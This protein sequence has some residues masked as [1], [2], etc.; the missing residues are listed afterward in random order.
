MALGPR[1]RISNRGLAI[2]VKSAMSLGLL[3]WRTSWRLTGCAW[4][5]AGV[6]AIGIFLVGVRGCVSFLSISQP[7][8]ADV[9]IVQG[10]LP[11]YALKG[12]S[13]EFRDG[14]Y[15]YLIT[16]GGPLLRGY[17]VSGGKTY[18]ELAASALV[19]FGVTT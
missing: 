5:L 16:T 14:R 2:S 10:S 4:L 17:Y 1:A 12:A 9:L 15:R 11:D 13:E 7:V 6:V 8:T 3:V 19:Q 18:A